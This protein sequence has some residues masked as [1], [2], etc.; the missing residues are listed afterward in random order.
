MKQF[1]VEQGGDFA[2]DS[3]RGVAD[4]AECVKRFLLR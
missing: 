4:C 3:M 2:H 1:F